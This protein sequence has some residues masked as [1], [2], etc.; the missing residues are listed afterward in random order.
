MKHVV[1]SL[2]AA[3]AVISS[4]LAQ[5]TA[6]F[7]FPADATFGL[8]PDPL[9]EET[10]SDGYFGEEYADTLHI[11]VP[12]SADDLV[13]IPLPVDSVVVQSIS[14]IGESGESLLISEVGLELTPNNNGDSGNP[15]AFL[16]GMQYCATLSGIPDTTGFFFASINVVGWASLFGSSISEEVPFEGYSLTIILE[17]CTD[18]MACNYEPLATEDDG[19]CAEFDALDVCG[20]DCFAADSTGCIE[21]IM[22]GC[23][24]SLACNY[25]SMA[26]TDDGSC[27]VIGETCDDMDEMTANDMITADCGCVGEAIVEGCTND[28]ACNYEDMANVDD[29]SCLVIGETCDDM[30]DMT[31]NDIVSDSC[32]CIGEPIVLGCLDTNACNYSMDA[33]VDDGSCLVIGEA[34]DDMN[35]MTVNDIVTDSC[36]CVGEAIV[37]GCTDSS[38]CNYVMGANVDDGSCLVIGDACDDNDEDTINDMI[39]EDCECAGEVD[40]VL[41]VDFELNVYPNPT[42]GE[43]IITLPVGHAFDLTLVSLSGQTVHASQT[44]QGGPVVWNVE[45]LPAGAYLL[46]VRNAHATAVRRVLVG[47][48]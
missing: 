16:G 41:E 48:R 7:D 3:F 24:D 33:N 45:G 6:D 12:T 2:A 28:E 43:V 25:E 21:Q 22:L 11:L 1:L 18:P 8:S 42:M 32:V 13:G 17:G 39:T 47:G 46:H 27:L 29:G 4:G 9:L 36:V 19:S 23:M 14:L 26:N 20:G 40:A 15:Y 37:E 38:A 31:V 5:C 35:D 34:C 30:D 10:F 44:T